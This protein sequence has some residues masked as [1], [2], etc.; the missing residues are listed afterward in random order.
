[1]SE[2][3][4]AKHERD[5]ANRVK[6]QP[7]IDLGDF[8]EPKTLPRLSWLNAKTHSGFANRKCQPG[9]KEEHIDAFY[10]YADATAEKRLNDAR[11]NLPDNQAEVPVVAAGTPQA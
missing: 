3:Q 2:K 8:V 1:M 11:P 6:P 10:A 7:T 9:R 5:N 4:R